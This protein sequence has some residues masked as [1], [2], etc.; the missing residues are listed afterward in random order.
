MSEIVPCNECGEQPWLKLCW[1]GHPLN[2]TPLEFKLRC[3]CSCMYGE[4]RDELIANWNKE[5]P[6]LDGST[7]APCLQKQVR[8]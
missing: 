5:N 3:G 4:N 7:S 1:R 6:V 8:P 2:G